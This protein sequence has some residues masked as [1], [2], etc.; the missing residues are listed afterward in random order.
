MRHGSC[1]LLSQQAS[2]VQI[3]FVQSDIAGAALRPQSVR[4][5]SLLRGLGLWSSQMPPGSSQLP[6]P[7]EP[8]CPAPLLC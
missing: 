3:L 2:P 4:A 8:L 6:Q 5:C 1:C 7:V